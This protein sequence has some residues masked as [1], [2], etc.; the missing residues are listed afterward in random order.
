MFIIYLL[1]TYDLNRRLKSLFET[2][3]AKNNEN[4][5][6]TDA[7]RRYAVL[8]APR[9]KMTNIKNIKIVLFTI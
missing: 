9:P 5:L 7:P 1:A 3:L 6:H 8:D 2:L 4:G